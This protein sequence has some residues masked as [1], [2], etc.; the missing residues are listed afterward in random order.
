MILVQSDF[1][2][3]NYLRLLDIDFFICATLRIL[4]LEH[5]RNLSDL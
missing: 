1:N 3:K 4:S 2:T 5:S